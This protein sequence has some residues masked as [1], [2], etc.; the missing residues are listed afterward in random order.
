M[1]APGEPPIRRRGR[2]ALAGL[3]VLAGMAHLVAPEVYLPAMPP[4][5]P[6]P[7]ALIYVSGL[8]EIAGG[9]GLLARSLPLRRAAGWGLALLLVAVY[10]ANV[11]LAL[12]AP[13]TTLA[14]LLLLLRL[15]LQGALIAWALRVSGV[16]RPGGVPRK[17]D[18]LSTP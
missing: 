14:G 1:G 7:L 2:W 9:V 13:G 11:H 16:V 18:A 5:F 17:G 8:A 6:A 10:P 4:A 3:M 15:P 12:S